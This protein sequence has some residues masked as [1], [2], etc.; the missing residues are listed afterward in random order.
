MFLTYNSEGL[1][2]VKRVF[3]LGIWG[4]WCSNHMYSNNNTD[5]NVIEF[6]LSSHS[7]RIGMDLIQWFYFLLKDHLKNFKVN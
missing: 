6:I 7:L 2:Y 1:M 4:F 3:K 5:H